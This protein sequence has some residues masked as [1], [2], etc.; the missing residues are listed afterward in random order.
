MKSEGLE[1]FTDTW[2]TLLGLMLF[3]A[4][5]VALVAWILRPSSKKYLQRAATLP[6]NDGD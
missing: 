3:V 2:M 4:V 6:F 1:Y 5:S